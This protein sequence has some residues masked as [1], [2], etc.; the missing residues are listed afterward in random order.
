MKLL[1]KITLFAL[2]FLSFS[3]SADSFCT[4]KI[5]QLAIGRSGTVLIAGPGGL[6]STYLCNVNSKNNNVATEACKAIYSQLLAA[7]AQ[8]KVVNITFNPAIDS[9]SKVKSWGWATGFN[10][11][12]VN[13]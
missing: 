13:D 2:V 10:W 8:D 5:K 1:K 3:A 11:V 12:I 6:P 4:G 9:C 7:H